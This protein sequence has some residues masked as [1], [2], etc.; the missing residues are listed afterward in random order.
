MLELEPSEE[1]AAVAEVARSI[2]LDVLSPAA[3]E[4]E[5]ARA[6]PP[7]VWRALLDSGL[8]V[9]VAEERGGGGV[10][11]TMTHML[12]V[13][14]LAYGD[15]G[16]AVAAAWSGAAAFLLGRH[17]ARDQDALLGR[18]LTDPD[19]RGSVALYEGFGRAPAEYAT[20]IAVD[21][22]RT[23]V[24]GRK[25]GV[26]FADRAESVIVVGNDDALS[27]KLRAV[28]VPA[29]TPGV[30]VE[31]NPGGLALDAAG[32][33]SVSYDVRVPSTN[34]VGGVD[35]DSRALAESVERIRLIIAAAQMGTAQRAIDYASRYAVD[36][37]AFGRPISSFQGISFPLAE[38]Q[39][40]VAELRLELSDIAA[41]LDAEPFEDLSDAVTRLLSFAGEVGAETTRNA[42]QTLGG[43]GFIVDHPVELWY[44]SAAALAALDF[45]LNRSSFQPAL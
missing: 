41:R 23:R 35:A 1:Q 12:A 20:T 42:V 36:R 16:I 13:E 9:P 38:A 37:I 24:T 21:G 29:G 4:A 22:D 3:R 27:G 7:V 39:V 11:D 17:G 5:A 26:A 2:G 15:P 30:L 10:P 31:P 40:R 33:G 43:H 25:V 18:L 6:V 28:V 44:R 14:S 45:E 32:I 34:L 19:A 8:T